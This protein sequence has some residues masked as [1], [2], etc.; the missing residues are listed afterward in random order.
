[1]VYLDHNATTAID[2]RVLEAMNPF[3]HHC[4]GNAS[5]LHKMGRIA[6]SAMDVAREQVAALV[7]ADPQQVIFTSGGTE[8]N[9]LALQPKNKNTQYALSTIEHPSVT[10]TIYTLSSFSPL[11]PHIIGV[12]S[13][14]T[15][16]KNALEDLKL[17]AHSIVSIMLA[18]NETGVIQALAEIADQLQSQNLILHTDAVQAVGK[19]PVDFNQLGVQRLTLSSHKIYGPKGCGA[20]VIEKNTSLKPLIIGG[21]QEQN[22]RS[23]TE[24]IAAIVGFGKAAELALTELDARTKTLLNLRDYLEAEL[25]KIPQLTIFSQTV[26]RLPNTVQFSIANTHGEMLLMQLD[27]QNIAVSSGSA[28]AATHGAPSS[29]LIAMGVETSL[30]QGAIRISLGKDNNKTDIDTFIQTLLTLII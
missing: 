23:G 5:S 11:A 27:Q 22:L 17:P 29:V 25:L 12:N 1:M 21:G 7:H 24:N 6:R 9:N 2:E 14:G 10:D 20:L 15:L 16:D 13:Q 4:Y 19:I 28:C 8:A 3:L 30:A 18:N 26:E